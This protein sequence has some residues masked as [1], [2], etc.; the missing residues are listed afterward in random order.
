VVGF[1]G[2]APVVSTK[3]IEVGWLEDN[4][5]SVASL[6]LGLISIGWSIF[7]ELVDRRQSG[8][9]FTETGGQGLLPS[10]MVPRWM[11]RSTTGLARAF[12]DDQ[13][14][15]SRILAVEFSILNMGRRTIEAKDMVSPLEI[16]IGGKD[17]ELIGK[18]EITR[19]SRPRFNDFRI[20]KVG[21]NA[22]QV[23]FSL[24]DP[25]QGAMGRFWY[26][27]S[28]KSKISVTGYVKGVGDIRH[29]QLPRPLSVSR[30][31]PTMLLV[32]A[33]VALVVVIAGPESILLALATGFLGFGIALR[34]GAH[35]LR[36][37]VPVE[38]R[39]DGEPTSPGSTSTD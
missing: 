18:P 15:G 36:A 35:R 27:G 31:V 39:E 23:A 26:S 29:R 17:S 20:E 25:G 8:L 38:L 1:N 30:I 19:Q 22:T 2:L 3:A 34:L 21:R 14:S 9:V 37:V 11:R 32:Y 4:W 7:N 13:P 16:R 5:L 6:A 12:P 28:A 10:W 24:V 33:L